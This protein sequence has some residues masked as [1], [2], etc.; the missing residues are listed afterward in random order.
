MKLSK[1]MTDAI[2]AQ[3]AMELHSSHLYLGMS[4]WCE[5]Q[6][7][8][9]AANWMR[10]QSEEEREHALRFYR[11]LADRNAPIV[12][13][14]IPRP[15]IS[16]DSLL[17]VFETSLAQEEKVSESINE[18]YGLAMEERNFGAVTELQWFLGEQVEEEKTARDIVAKLRLIGDDGPA[19][20]EMDRILSVRIEEAGGEG[21]KE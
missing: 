9:G 1:R 21:G 13:A 6:S 7:L 8:V 14:E 11:F 2:N 20:L 17:H 15:G 19:L 10:Q 3:I 18:L 5:A 16:F 12:L 4:A